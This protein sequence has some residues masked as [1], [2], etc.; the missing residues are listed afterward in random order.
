MDYAN[1]Q[2]K[3]INKAKH[4]QNT[5]LPKALHRQPLAFPHW[6]LPYI[7]WHIRRLIARLM[8]LF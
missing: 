1:E 7:D 2:S 8:T 3:K 6:L 4:R 5:Q